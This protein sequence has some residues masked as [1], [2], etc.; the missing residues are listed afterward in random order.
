MK[1]LLVLCLLVAA[2]LSSKA[3]SAE[4]SV[5]AAVA[6]LFDAMKRGDSVLLVNSFT[7]NAILQ[8]IS[9]DADGLMAKNESVTGFARSISRA[10]KGAL[11]ERI[12][13]ESIKIDGPL[14]S[15]WTPYSF[16]YNGAF[17]HCGVN[18]F[19]LLRTA[20]GWKIHYLVDTR[21]K[22]SCDIK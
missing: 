16:F 2:G 11:D 18:S 21:R 14:A 19:Q 17:S 13:F 3:Q 15:V 10:P 9:K 12:S 20:A 22:T 1:F 8:A 7:K 5:K 4:D 6:Q